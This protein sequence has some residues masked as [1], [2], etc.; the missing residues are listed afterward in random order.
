VNK[1]S[2]I[3]LRKVFDAAVKDEA[4][5]STKELSASIHS[6]QT[7]NDLL[8]SENKGLRQALALKR[9]H[10]KK[11]KPLDLQ[12]RKEYH[13]GAVFWSPSKLREGRFRERVK[14]Q[15]EEAEKLQKA[16]TRESWERLINCTRKRWLRKQR[17]YRKVRKKPGQK[18]AKRQLRKPPRGEPKKSK[19]KELVTLKKLYNRLKEAREQLQSLLKVDR[20]S[21]GVIIALGWVLLRRN[22]HHQLH[23]KQHEFD[24]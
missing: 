21:G 3:Q 10:K 1:S 22:L 12:Q 24:Q 13:G 8:N 14:Q 18:S 2:W 17:R 23:L 7:H 11:S 9:K 15:E 4:D 19:K 16:Q 20:Q 6:L 5:E